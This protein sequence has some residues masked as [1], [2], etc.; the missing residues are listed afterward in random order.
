MNA[1]CGRLHHFGAMF[2][3]Y[4][5]R[6]EHVPRAEQYCLRP[7]LGLHSIARHEAGCRA[8]AADEGRRAGPSDAVRRRRVLHRQISKQSA[9]FENS[10]ERNACYTAGGAAGIVRAA[11]RGGRGPPGIDRIHVRTGDA[12]RA[13]P[14]ALLGGQT[15]WI[16][17][18]RT[19]GAD[20]GSRFSARRSSWS[21]VRNLSGLP[22]HFCV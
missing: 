9:T 6:G 18:P 17:V 22:R 15:V 2:A 5:V 11:G 4:S 10:G 13:G 1:L 8:R 14:Q 19:S 21:R 3:G 12:A 20:D 16:A 7:G